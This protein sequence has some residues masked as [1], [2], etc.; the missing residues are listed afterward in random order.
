MKAYWNQMYDVKFDPQILDHLSRLLFNERKCA[1]PAEENTASALPS[2]LECD[3]AFASQ[4]ETVRHLTTIIMLL[5]V[6]RRHRGHQHVP[7][8]FTASIIATSI[9]AINIT[10]IVSVVHTSC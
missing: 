3:T 6:C 4:E 10:V 1:Q 7:I 8:I 2:G 9:T 5:F